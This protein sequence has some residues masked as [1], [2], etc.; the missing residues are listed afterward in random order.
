MEKTYSLK[1]L[2]IIDDALVNIGENNFN[3]L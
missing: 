2:S 1:V 3:E